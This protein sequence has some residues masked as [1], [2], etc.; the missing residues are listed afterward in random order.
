MWNNTFEIS[1]G[2]Y[3]VSDIQ[4]YFDYIFKKHGKDT[5]NPSI[6]ISLN[7]KE[8]R[9]TFKL[10]VDLELL[11]LETVRLLES[12]E[13]KITITETMRLLGSTEDKITKDR[14]D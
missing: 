2:S 12:T 6:T 7:K 3:S 9:I 4:Y 13:D 5:D 10:R 11:T 14:N 1:D 8:N